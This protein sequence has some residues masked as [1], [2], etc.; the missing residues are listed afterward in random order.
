MI[1]NAKFWF[2]EV[3]D[4]F[5]GEA[6]YC[7]VKRFRVKASTMQGAM[8]VLSRHYGFNWRYHY[9]DCMFARYNAKRACICAFIEALN[10]YNNNGEAL[11]FDPTIEGI[12]EEYP[13]DQE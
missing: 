5:A 3:T 2:I 10:E 13:H 1:K 12:T 7:W 4:T 9:G 11:N 6:N 8:S